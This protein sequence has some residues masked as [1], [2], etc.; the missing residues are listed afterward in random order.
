[1]NDK[2]KDNL[3]IIYNTLKLSNDI[4]CCTQ[5][6]R[7]EAELATD[8][9]SRAELFIMKKYLQAM[10]RYPHML[11]K[12]YTKKVTEADFFRCIWSPIFEALFP[13]QDQQ[14]RI[15]CG[16]SINSYT[17]EKKANYVDSI[18][19][20]YIISLPNTAAS[21]TLRHPLSNSYYKYISQGEA[22]V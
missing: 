14:I 7:Q 12:P 20:S 9:T 10:H 22:D 16:E 6:I 21:R 13:L 1:L 19:W 4:K 11:T 15:K 8:E 2:I 17:T 18:Y 5:L 3:I